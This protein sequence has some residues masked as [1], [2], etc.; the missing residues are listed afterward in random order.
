[1]NPI[2]PPVD[3]ELHQRIHGERVSHVV[4]QP[5]TEKYRLSPTVCMFNSGGVADIISVAIVKIYLPEHIKLP[6]ERIRK[7]EVEKQLSAWTIA[8]FPRPDRKSPDGGEEKRSKTGLR[9]KVETEKFCKYE[10]P[11]IPSHDPL[12]G[13][14]VSSAFSPASL[15]TPVLPVGTLTPSINDRDGWSGVAGGRRR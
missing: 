9:R 10:R 2:H 7:A 13:C 11:T 12:P 6:Q 1:M 15:S 4:P 8:E 3:R 5:R 14:S